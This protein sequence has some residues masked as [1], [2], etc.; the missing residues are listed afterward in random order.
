ML[1]PGTML[2]SIV[3]PTWS[4]VYVICTCR[5]AVSHR[6]MRPR[7]RPSTKGIGIVHQRRPLLLLFAV[8]PLTMSH[9][10]IPSPYG[11]FQGTLFQYALPNL[12][13]FESD[14][15]CPNK[16]IL[17][18]GLSDGLIPTPYVKELEQEA[19]RV[20]WSLVQPILSSSYLGFGSGDLNRDSSELTLLLM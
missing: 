9:R 4:C 12:V 20:N 7:Q 15:D 14:P 10:T 11:T 3:D 5:L 18:G 19:K 8:L 6:N 1:A 13:A 2:H 16:C 17:L